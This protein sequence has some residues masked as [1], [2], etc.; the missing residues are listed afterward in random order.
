MKMREVQVS[1]EYVETLCQKMLEWV[2]KDDSYTIPQFLQ[3]KGIG[4]PYL[5]YI[6]YTYPQAHNAFEVMKAILCNRWFFLAMKKDKLPQHQAKMLMRYLRLY[7]SHALDVE[8]EAKK[9]V[10]EAETKVQMQYL[11]EYYDRSELTEPYKGIYDQNID[12][13]RSSKKAK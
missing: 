6:I 10:A 2:K 9:S 11:A 5:K 12:K 4:Y 7:D 3:W 13:R 1:T 8:E